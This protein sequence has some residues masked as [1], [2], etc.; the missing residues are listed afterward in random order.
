MGVKFNPLSG[1]FDLIGGAGGSAVFTGSLSASVAA[2]AT[3]TQNVNVGTGYFN[4]FFIVRSDF[5]NGAIGMIKQS[6]GTDY[7]VAANL[8][9]GVYSGVYHKIVDTNLSGI[10]GPFYGTVGSDKLILKDV[11]FDGSGNVA[12]S[13]LSQEASLS[14][15]LSCKYKLVVF[16]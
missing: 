4:G 3:S 14:K 9:A 13:F 1:Q 11:V 7:A 8:T 16:A 15:T 5:N 2:G 10:T 12:I 6:A